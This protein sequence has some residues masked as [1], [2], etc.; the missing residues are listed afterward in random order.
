LA[1]AVS[2]SASAISD[3]F[4]LADLN[5]DARPEIVAVTSTYNLMGGTP[6]VL[7]LG[8]LG[9]GAFAPGV[10]YALEHD[11]T[12]GIGDLTGDGKPEIVVTNAG[13]NTLTVL[14]NKG[15]GTF[16]AQ[17][18]VPLTPGP[19]AVSVGDVNGDGKGDVYWF[20]GATFNAL[21]GMGDGTFA[22]APVTTAFS[23]A[24]T[25]VA[26]DLNG[27]GAIDVAF[28]V[29]GASVSIA[30]NKGD[31]TFPSSL[32]LYLAMA[33]VT[34]LSLADW[35][36]DGTPDLLAA[37]TPSTVL[38]NDGKGTFQMQFA[39]TTPPAFS[40]VADMNGDGQTDLVAL[41]STGTAD[42]A[43]VWLNSGNNTFP[44]LVSTPVA[45]YA[46]EVQVGDLNGD[47]L[48]DLVSLSQ[49]SSH[50]GTLSV[51]L[52]TCPH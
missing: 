7:V 27:D 36:G 47:G 33:S 39:L 20:A 21:Y 50:L 24:A 41:I 8:N 6:E 49:P 44:T 25:L 16:A 38:L 11:T 1:P 23:S 14:L 5:G 45:R 13:S 15:D 51:V 18:A 48:L 30:L 26:A 2:Y 12:V 10:P 35:N 43:G 9:D 19:S 3:S 34:G 31:G 40:V 42:S 52:N 17:P 28:S 22:A 46:S 4:A 32:A 37:G 29:A